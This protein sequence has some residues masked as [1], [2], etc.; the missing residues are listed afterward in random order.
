MTNRKVQGYFAGSTL[1]WIAIIAMFINHF[2]DIILK[3]IIMNAPY[4]AFSNLFKLYLNQL[5]SF[6]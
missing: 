3:G 5:F 6:Q 4:S 1:K 2:G